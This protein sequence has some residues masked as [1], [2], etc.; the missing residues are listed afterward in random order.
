MKKRIV[1]LLLCCVMLLTL[2]PSLIATAT[3]EDV[4]SGAAQQVEQTDETQNEV[5]DTEQQSEQVKDEDEAV[6]DKATTLEASGDV[7][8][9]WVNTFRLHC[10]SNNA[11]VAWIAFD[12]N[13]NTTNPKLTTI[14]NGGVA[15]FDYSEF[16]GKI[17]IF[18][19]KPS[20]NAL[21]TAVTL[22]QRN[23]TTNDNVDLYGVEVA[24]QD[25]AFFKGKDSK[26]Q[27][28]GQAIINAAKA[29]GYVGYFGYTVNNISV[30]DHYLTIIGKKPGIVVSASAA[31][32]SDVKPGTKIT[33]TVK[34]TPQSTGADDEK[35]EKVT[36]K[37]LTLNGK[38]LDVED[39]ELT[40]SADGSYYT[41][42]IEHTVTEKEWMDSLAT[43]SV[44]AEME[45]S[46]SLPVSDRSKVESKIKSTV[47]VTG[48]DSTDCTFETAKGIIYKLNFAPAGVTPREG[49]IPNAPVDGETYFSNQYATV[50]G[51]SKG[52]DQITKGY[53]IDDPGNGGTW[54]FDGWYKANDD[55]DD[56][57]YSADDKILM[58]NSVILTGTWTF[59]KYPYTD[60]TI[61][62]T[63][64]AG[65]PKDPNQSAV[66]VVTGGDLGEGLTVVLNEGNEYSVT[67]KG[68]KVG[69]T[70]TVTEKTWTWRYT[71]D[72]NGKKITLNTDAKQNEVEFTNT[73]EKN[74]WLTG[75]AWC[76]NS[77]ATG[78][79]KGST[80]TDYSTNR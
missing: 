10:T 59:A 77:W 32:A 49:L 17:V 54:T 58:T 24:A 62:K 42:V 68:L 7:S 13:T 35:I 34:V 46:Y 39:F 53:V 50:K 16:Q 57:A 8:V 79:S 26:L 25:S 47:T 33:Y 74:K 5:K 44:T 23:D 3:A 21:L 15:T 19:V 43:I 64:A 72:G 28:V 12:A 18:F 30:T 69:T 71:P 78:T 38:V 51:Y 36:L 75:G 48:T 27:A 6:A 31:P 67:I 29:A 11:E 1:A 66:F 73:L 2:S 9:Y 60:L 14:S 22:G 61:T 41:V 45:Y 4:T 63:Y 52:D 20:A 40:K 80:S 70:Y 55:N 37:E 65:A 56:K 76:D